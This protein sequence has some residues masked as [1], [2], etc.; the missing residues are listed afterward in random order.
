MATIESDQKRKNQALRLAAKAAEKARQ[1]DRDE[2]NACRFA[3]D[4]GAS[5]REIAEAVSRPHTTVARI[6]NRA[7]P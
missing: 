1:A 7:E 2:R 3:A 6:I 5:L 4:A